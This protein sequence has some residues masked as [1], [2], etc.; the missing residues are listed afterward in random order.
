[1]SEPVYIKYAKMLIKAY[2]YHSRYYQPYK[3]KAEN[4]LCKAYF[5]RKLS[6]S[7]YYKLLDMHNTICAFISIE[8][9]EE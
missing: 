4:V 1:M 3:E 8:E 2:R 6:N 9:S 5:D 7:E